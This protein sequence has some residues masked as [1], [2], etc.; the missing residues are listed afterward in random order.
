VIHTVGPIYGREH[1]KE[2]E[3][4]A[5]C[6]RSRLRL[7]VEH[8]I[9]TIAFP[10]ISTGAYGYPIEEASTIAFNTV[11]IFMEDGKGQIEK[12]YFVSFSDA[13]LKIYQN[14]PP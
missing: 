9:K 1:G 2:A 13:D 3:L 5:S 10:S 6:Y 11:R 7:A 8:N 12:V 4:L 14:L